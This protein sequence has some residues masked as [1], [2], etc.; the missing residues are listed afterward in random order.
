MVNQIQVLDGVVQ[1]AGVVDDRKTAVILAGHLR[2]AAG[3]EQRR[4]QDEVRRR[5]RQVRQ[6]LVKVAHRDPF[7]EIM[8]RDDVAEH[9]LKAAVRC[10]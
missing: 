3:L 6:P 8:E 7:V 5:E 10:V 1:P 2:Q 4:H 9:L